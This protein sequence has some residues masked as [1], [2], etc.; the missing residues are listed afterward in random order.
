MATI[1]MKRGEKYADI[2]DSSE[3]IAQAEKDG[4]VRC[5]EEKKPT[6]VSESENADEKP[7]KKTSRQ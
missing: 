7:A 6:K 4:Y 5:A 3:T 1:K 2:F